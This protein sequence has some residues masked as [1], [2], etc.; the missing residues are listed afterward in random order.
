MFIKFVNPGLLKSYGGDKIMLK[1]LK[2]TING[3]E[4]DNQRLIFAYIILIYTK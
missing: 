4:I 2:M 1:G 3:L